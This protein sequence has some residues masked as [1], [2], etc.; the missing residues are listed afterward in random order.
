MNSSCMYC[1]TPVTHREFCVECNHFHIF[2]NDMLNEL[3]SAIEEERLLKVKL[4]DVQKNRRTLER[5][6]DLLW[7]KMFKQHM[8]TLR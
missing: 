8:P 6:Y 4:K 3:L 2:R 5:K 1:S 7:D